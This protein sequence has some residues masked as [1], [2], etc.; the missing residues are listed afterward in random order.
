MKKT[1]IKL[2]III[3]LIVFNSC[4]VAKMPSASIP[5]KINENKGM[6]IGAIALNKSGSTICN[7][8]R[9]YYTNIENKEIDNPKENKIEIVPSQAIYVHFKPDFF[10]NEDAIYYFSIE[11]PKGKYRFYAE[12]I[13]M[14]TYS[15]AI[16]ETNEINIPF[17]IEEGKAK[18]IGQLKFN[19]DKTYEKVD[20]SERDLENLRKLY[21]ELNIEK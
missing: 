19:A 3:I 7:G 21:P 2:Q 8:Y 6:I 10:D 17:E 14:N 15:Q 4:T 9:Y 13:F 5:K 16:Y 20:K 12:R 18:Y 11:K 1:L